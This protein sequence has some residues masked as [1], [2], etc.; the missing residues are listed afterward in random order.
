MVRVDFILTQLGGGFWGLTGEF[1]T[2]VGS[3]R[4]WGALGQ[5]GLSQGAWGGF[6]RGV[7]HGGTEGTEC[8]MKARKEGKSRNRILVTETSFTT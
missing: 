1:L 7:S 8:A 2:E 5:G 3:A 6:E 4:R